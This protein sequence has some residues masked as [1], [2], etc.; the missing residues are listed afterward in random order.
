MRIPNSL[1]VIQLT[2]INAWF[3]LIKRAAA[4]IGF[5]ERSRQIFFQEK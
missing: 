2:S 5:V 1:P 4:S 3:G